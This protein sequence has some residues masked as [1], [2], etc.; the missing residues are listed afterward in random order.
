M[1][2]RVYELRWHSFR[3]Q[4]GKYKSLKTLNVNLNAITIVKAPNQLRLG[5]VLIWSQ[6]ASTAGSRRLVDSGGGGEMMD[7]VKVLV[8]CAVSILMRIELIFQYN[9]TSNENITKNL[10]SQYNIF[11]IIPLYLY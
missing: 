6:I 7:E 2:E 10:V 5:D 3:P 1:F 11:I 9:S 4:S 8:Y